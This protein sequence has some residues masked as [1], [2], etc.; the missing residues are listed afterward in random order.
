MVDYVIPASYI[1]KFYHEEVVNTESYRIPVNTIK[2]VQSLQSRTV[3][4]I[5]ANLVGEDYSRS[6]L[7]E[8]DLEEV[9]K[10]LFDRRMVNVGYPWVES[11]INTY[12]N[13]ISTK[14]KGSPRTTKSSK[15]GLIFSPNHVKKMILTQIRCHN[16][17]ENF[18]VGL[19][20]FLEYLT[21]EMLFLGSEVTKDSGIITIYPAHVESGIKTDEEMN[22]FYGE[23]LDELDVPLNFTS[24]K[25]HTAPT[26][27]KRNRKNNIKTP[28]RAKK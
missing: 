14:V 26:K 2:L 23:I 17:T 1:K 22:K 18:V 25:R 6:R 10:L 3:E 9:I 20:A 21:G 28:N 12:R 13:S 4:I 5:G 7:T 11:A 27:L 8:K 15:A 16:V 19:T 24:P